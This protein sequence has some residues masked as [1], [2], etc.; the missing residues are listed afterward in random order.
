MRAGTIMGAQIPSSGPQFY[1]RR[2]G[3][4]LRQ[5]REGLL[6]TLLPS[7]ELSL[8]A[9][10][11]PLDTAALFGR[12]VRDIWLEIGFGSGEHLIWQAQHHSDV[13]IIG[14]EPFLNG[15]AR[16]LS[17]IADGNVGNVRIVPDDVR[18]TLDQLPT[19][20]LGRV[21]ILFPDPWQKV[22][23]HKRRLVNEETLDQLANVMAEGAELRMATDDA[24]Y[25]AWMLR[26][27][28]AHSAFEWLARRPDD[29]RSRPDDWP[30]TRYEQKN[31]SGGQGPVFLRFCRR[32]R[33]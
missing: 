9:D 13:G 17:Y 2:R 27:G 6:A 8:P 25:A 29:W 12:P 28:L 5:H 22:R 1:G 18:P 10:G 32:S 19:A 15:V 23:H 30:S 24:D 26:I 16:L 7:L 20:S 11:S 33:N 4:R 3:R 21:F 14:A 31:R